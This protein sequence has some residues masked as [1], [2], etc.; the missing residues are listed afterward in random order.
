[1]KIRSLEL[2]QFRNI[3]AERIPFRPGVNILYGSNAQGKTNVMEAIQLLSTGKSHRT[4]H[5]EEMIRYGQSAFRLIAEVD[6]GDRVETVEM[7]LSRSGGREILINGVKRKRTSE[8]LGLLR[9]LQFSPETLEIVKGGPSE[10]RRYMDMI[11]CQIR[12]T[13]LANLQRYAAVLKEKASALRNREG[14]QKYAPMIPIW[15]A[16]LARCGGV[17]RK[18]RHE[19]RRQLE[20]GMNREMAILSNGRES[21]RLVLRGYP[22]DDANE[23]RDAEG[24]RR[25]DASESTEADL[26]GPHPTSV[27]LKVAEDASSS[28]FDAKRFEAGI[29][30][31]MEKNNR[32]EFELGQC[33]VGPHRDDLEIF[34][35]G[36][37]SRQFCSQGQQRSI[38]LAMILAS[39]SFFREE[40][41]FLPILLLDDVMS[42][43]D[44]KRRNFLIQAL[45]NTQ[46]MITTT[47]RQEYEGR[48]TGETAYWRVEDGHVSDATKAFS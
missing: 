26:P 41:G 2:T 19:M 29:L 15:N 8:L 7:R 9:V 40:T 33:L 24:F 1:M 39:M 11:L 38:A 32:R 36:K 10:R 37:S 46:T 21:V 3:E 30:K 12:P 20:T 35:N 42:E 17:I 6:T 44:E 34:L 27:N 43:L 47:D 23:G 45:E 16:E 31:E 48:I 13:Y 14:Q 5:L 22:S 18:I 25:R 4:K 28:K